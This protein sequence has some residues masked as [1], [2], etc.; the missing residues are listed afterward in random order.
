MY[1]LSFR[2]RGGSF[3]KDARNAFKK[4]GCTMRTLYSVLVNKF[5][6]FPR[7]HPTPPSR[8][9]LGRPQPRQPSY[10]RSDIP[11]HSI[12]SIFVLEAL[13]LRSGKSLFAKASLMSG[14]FQRVPQAASTAGWLWEGQCH[15]R[16]CRGGSFTLV[17]MT[18][19][20]NHLVQD[21][22]KSQEL[23]ITGMTP[24]VFSNKE[25]TCH[26]GQYY[27]PIASNNPMFDAFFLMGRK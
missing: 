10:F 13:Y 25:L 9:C 18:A 20:G 23:E 17:P 15:N 7:E 11:E 2:N 24:I 27:V 3:D 22:T 21:Q 14:L 4:Y 1:R 26:R 5:M 16:I 12:P 19:K 6:S 8:H